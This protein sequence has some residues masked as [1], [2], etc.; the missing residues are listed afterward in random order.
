MAAPTPARRPAPRPVVRPGRAAAAPERAPR[1]APQARPELRLVDGARLKASE[2]RR[3]ARLMVVA[4]AT[5]ATICLFL[6]A[7]FNA[8]LVSGQGRIDRLERQVQEAQ[9]RYSTNRLRVAELESPDRIVRVA[10]ERLGMVPP[11]GVTYLTPSETVAD[12]VGRPALPAGETGTGRPWA[13]VKPYLSST[14]R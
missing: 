2:R 12:E 7:A 5:F 14:P 8:L 6:L 1:Q 10:Q 11:P 4:A 9:A 3:R 13:T